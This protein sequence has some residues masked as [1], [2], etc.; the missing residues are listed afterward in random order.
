MKD[1]VKIGN[2]YIVPS[3][4][5]LWFTRL[6]QS[7]TTTKDYVIEVSNT[8]IGDDNSFF[9]QLYEIIFGQ[10]IPGT[11]KVLHGEVTCNVKNLKHI[12]DQLKPK[13]GSI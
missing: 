6:Q 4:T 7:F 1:K 10:A 12:T 11:I 9:G 13:I 2:K 8:I 3:G 5:T